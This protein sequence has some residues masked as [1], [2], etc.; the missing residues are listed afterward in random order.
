MGARAPN[1]YIWLG[2]GTVARG[3][4]ENGYF[5]LNFNLGFDICAEDSVMAVVW[6]T[7]FDFNF[8]IFGLRVYS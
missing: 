2:M 4:N 8:N 5:A 7:D 6:K 1:F 3:E